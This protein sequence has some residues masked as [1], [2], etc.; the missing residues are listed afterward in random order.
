VMPGFFRLI[1]MAIDSGGIDCKPFF[2]PGN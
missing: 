1:S 2:F